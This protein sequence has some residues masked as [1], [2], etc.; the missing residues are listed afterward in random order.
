MTFRDDAKFDTTT[1]RRRRGGGATG[2]A[3]AVGGGGL[4]TVI[5]L[6]LSSFLGID[7]TGLGGG[8]T[9]SDPSADQE[10]TGCDGISADDPANLD[11]RMEAG[12]DSMSQYW[13]T[14]FA[15]NQLQYQDPTVLL[16]DGQVSS[17]CGQASSAVGPF[18]CPTDTQ[19]YIDTSFFAQM[20]SQFG[21]QG[22]SAAELYV[23]AHEWGHH[24]QQLTGDLQRVQPN[25]TG[26]T[27]SAVR[28][29]LQADC[30]AGAWLGQ[31]S[32][33]NDDDGGAPV[34]EPI[35]QE[36]LN[37]A[38]DSAMA[39][40]DDNLQEHAGQGINPD[41][42]THGSSEQ[43]QSWLSAGFTGGAAACA[44]VWTVAQP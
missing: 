33:V 27:G 25:D 35:T 22:G 30:Y 5:L 32:G 15:E 36:Q 8:T 34:L 43:R 21:A 28:S 11:C 7:L 13:E 19:I 31:A 37:Q 1:V 14:V 23:L 39:I 29:E 40:G 41:A 12:A 9:S 3:I 17:G 10:I 42:W 16:Y 26:P 6:V 4:L 20:E 44:A 24:I 18:Y 2:G 38:L